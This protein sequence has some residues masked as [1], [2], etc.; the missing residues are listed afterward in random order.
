MFYQI[1]KKRNCPKLKSVVLWGGTVC[2]IREKEGRRE[3]EKITERDR[4]TEL[5]EFQTFQYIANARAIKTF[6]YKI[7]KYHLKC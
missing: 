5:D 4:S 7:T 1:S 6:M 3:R 2:L